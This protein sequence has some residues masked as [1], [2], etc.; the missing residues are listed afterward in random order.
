MT[1]EMQICLFLMKNGESP[2]YSATYHHHLR[3]VD[4]VVTAAK[5]PSVQKLLQRVVNEIAYERAKWL[6]LS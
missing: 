2:K 1:S 4:S 5:I 6:L 3:V